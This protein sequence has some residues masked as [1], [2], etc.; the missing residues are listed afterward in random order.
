MVLS[1]GFR[2]AAVGLV[3]G[4]PLTLGLSEGLKRLL[5]ATG[6]RD[7]VVFTGVPLVLLVVALA[8]TYIPAWRA[9][10]VQPIVALRCE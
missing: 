5:A 2:L 8:A 7:I 4:M 9:T 10:H 6:A 1:H 3:L